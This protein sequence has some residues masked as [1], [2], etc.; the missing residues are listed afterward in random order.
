LKVLRAAVCSPR[1]FVLWI[2]EAIATR[3]VPARLTVTPFVRA[4]PRS[5]AD[6]EQKLGIS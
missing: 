2:V 1:L 3:T 4:L 5:W 6:H